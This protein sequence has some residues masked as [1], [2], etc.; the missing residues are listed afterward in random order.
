MTFYCIGDEETARGFRLAGIDARTAATPEEALAAFNDIAS[1]P[2]C[3]IIIIT[4]TV[5]DWLRPHVEMI[6]M[7]R[8]RPLIAE[9][10]GPEGPTAGRR[11]LHELVQ[12]AVGVSVG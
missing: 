6:R 10:P 3:G 11:S 2:D 9:I 8:D 5:A 12:E 7:E 4:D 1:R